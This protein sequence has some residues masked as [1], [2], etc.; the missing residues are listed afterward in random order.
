[1][2]RIPDPEFSI[3][4]PTDTFQYPRVV[5]VLRVGGI[6]IEVTLLDSGGLPIPNAFVE[7]VFD[8]TCTDL[9]SCDSAVL[10][11]NAEVRRTPG[12]SC[13]PG[14]VEAAPGATVNDGTSR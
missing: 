2:S 4:M 11:G 3:V 8:P 10:Q 12:R 6:P 7:M 13:S 14:A 1:M 9:C 5:G